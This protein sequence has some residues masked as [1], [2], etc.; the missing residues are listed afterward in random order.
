MKRFFSW[1]EHTTLS[2]FVMPELTEMVGYI[3]FAFLGL[4][5]LNIKNFW[6]SV[7]GGMPLTNQ[8]FQEAFGDSALRI[9][10]LLNSTVLGNAVVFVLWGLVGCVAYIIFWLT[11]NSLSTINREVG[12]TYITGSK[13]KYSYLQS[14]IAHYLFFAALSVVT[15][16]LLYA[17]IWIVLP[18]LTQMFYNGL[19]GFSPF[20]PVA[21]VAGLGSVLALTII[22]HVMALLL[23][24]YIRFWS[25]YIKAN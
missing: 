1:N 12:H 7:S 2:S 14:L 8:G 24:V 16:S 5:I 25:M 6:D 10:H 4:C 18:A 13:K 17:L 23:Q 3:L 19:T 11:Q 22:M 9:D 15:I 20:S 21:L